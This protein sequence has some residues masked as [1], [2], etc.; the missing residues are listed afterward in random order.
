VK[1]RTGGVVARAARAGVRRVRALRRCA[2]AG[3]TVTRMSAN[4]TSTLAARRTALFD[5]LVI[6]FQSLLGRLGRPASFAGSHI[7]D[8]RP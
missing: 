7:N 2:E 8:R 3:I 1:K 5:F 6:T 4:M